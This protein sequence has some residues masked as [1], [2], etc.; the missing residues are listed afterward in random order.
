M[1]HFAVHVVHAAAGDI[2]LEVVFGVEDGEPIGLSALK[3]LHD[4]SHGSLVAE[5]GGWLYHQ[6]VSLEV[7]V[8]LGAEH[9][10]TN[11]HDIDFA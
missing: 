10:M 4:L 9:D 5:H 6:L 3:G 7:V 1:Y 8:K 2:A 11:L